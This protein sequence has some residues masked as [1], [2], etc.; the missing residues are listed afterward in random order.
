MLYERDLRLY[1]RI[2]L[3]RTGTTTSTLYTAIGYLKALQS[4]IVEEHIYHYMFQVYMSLADT[5]DSRELLLSIESV[6]YCTDLPHYG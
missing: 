6:S 2:V 3:L 1:L 5:N 4:S